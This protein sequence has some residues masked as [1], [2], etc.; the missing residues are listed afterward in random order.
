MA[1]A[2]PP[3]Q[4]RWKKENTITVGLT[5]S[6]GADPEIYDMLVDAPNRGA[7]IKDILREH[8]QKIEKE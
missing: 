4:T 7:I 6:R 3:S 8:I 2:T 1:T 5:I